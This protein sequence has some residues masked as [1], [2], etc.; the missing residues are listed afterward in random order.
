MLV[1][2]PVLLIMVKF[3]NVNRYSQSYN[4]LWQV[5]AVQ[6]P[7]QFSVETLPSPL[8][9]TTAVWWYNTV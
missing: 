2:G 9:G 4:G 1:L 5:G 6:S 7:T 3:L 8:F